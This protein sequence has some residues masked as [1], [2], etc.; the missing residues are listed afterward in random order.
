MGDISYAINKQASKG[1]FYV[2]EKYTG[3][4]IGKNL[5]E[6]PPIPNEGNSGEGYRLSPGMVISVEPI[7]KSSSSKIMAS[8][9]IWGILTGDNSVSAHFEHTIAITSGGPKILTERKGEGII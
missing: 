5:H 8:D 3:H 4:G 9:E 7:L 1:G 6:E 2:V